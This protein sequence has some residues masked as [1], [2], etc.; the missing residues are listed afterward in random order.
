[1]KTSKPISAESSSNRRAQ[2]VRQTRNNPPRPFHSASRPFGGKDVA[3][4][5]RGQSPPLHSEIFPAIT[6]FTDAITALPKELVRHFTLLKEVDAKIFAPEEALGHLVDAALNSV[7]PEPKPMT[8]GGFLNIA[9]TSAPFSAPGSINGSVLNGRPGSVTSAIDP[10]AAFEPENLPRRQLFGQCAMTMQEMLISLDEK[11]HVISTAV[12]AMNRGLARLDGCFP[13]IER[14]ISD[15]ARLGNPNHWAYIDNRQSPRSNEKTRKEA[16]S[17]ILSAAQQAGESDAQAAKSE[18]RR[19]AVLAKK[20]N[21]NAH[22]GSDFEDH[23]GENGRKVHGNT[24][25]RRPRDEP[26]VGLGITNG[27]NGNAPKRVKTSRATNGATGMERSASGVTGSS[28]ANAKGKAGSPR[29]TPIPEP[30]KRLPRPS[31]PAATTGR[32]RCV[33]FSQ[34]MV[35]TLIDVFLEPV[36]ASLSLNRHRS[37]PR[38]CTV[39]LLMRN[40]PADLLCQPHDQLR[41]VGDKILHNRLSTTQGKGHHLQHQ[42]NQMGRQVHQILM[43][44]LALLAALY[45]K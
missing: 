28:A 27:A 41:V 21:R 3:D 23:R 16:A 44:W 11:N 22:A 30:K 18:A 9:P 4:G 10:M 17:V 31:V 35:H 38:Q 7:P 5:L 6:H 37:P 42:T 14:E 1:M 40:L 43:P 2:P 34:P 8:D 36:L 19:Q 15:E 24:K 20:N 29:E 26:S 39:L 45:Q 32:K 13:Y 33:S 25:I 12:E